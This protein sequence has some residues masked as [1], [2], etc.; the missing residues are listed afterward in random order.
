[1]ILCVSSGLSHTSVYYSP[2]RGIVQ[3]VAFLIH[4]TTVLSVLLI[5]QI[6]LQWEG[7]LIV[8]NKCQ[9]YICFP[10]GSDG[11]ESDCNAGDPD[12]LPGLGRCPGE[13][14]GNPLQ[15]SWLKNPMNRGALWAT[16]RGIMKSWTWLSN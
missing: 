14:N 2:S 1:M 13:G 10:G 3:L 4:L 9:I 16:V 12:L 5:C 8:L 7:Q 6:Y 11:K 15:Y